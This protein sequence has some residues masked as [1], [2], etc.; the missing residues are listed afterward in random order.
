MD[1]AS[2]TGVKE[3]DPVERG[4]QDLYQNSV[5]DKFSVSQRG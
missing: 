1:A 4:H 3:R 2:V 5:S